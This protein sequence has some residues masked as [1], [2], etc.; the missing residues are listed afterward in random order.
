MQ[1]LVSKAKIK[2][3]E[4]SIT[5]RRQIPTRL[6]SDKYQLDYILIQNPDETTRELLRNARATLYEKYDEL[7]EENISMKIDQIDNAQHDNQYKLSWKLIN[8]ISGRKASR[9]GQIEGDT[10]EERTANWFKHFQGLLGNPPD[11][12]GQDEEIDQIIEELNINDGPFTMEEYNKAKR[13]ITEGKACGEDN[14][15]PEVLKRCNLDEEILGFC[16]RALLEG[17]KPE[18]WSIMNII[19]I[20]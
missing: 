1:H 18:Q 19:P 4:S 5:E 6:Y 20:P 17:R 12:G 13:S 11:I 10:K 7:E 2:A 15:P 9:K 16:N 3:M 14:I 8:E